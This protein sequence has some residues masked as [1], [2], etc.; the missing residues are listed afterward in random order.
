MI[1]KEMIAEKVFAEGVAKDIRNFLPAKYENAEFQVMQMNKNNG[2]QMV[3]VQ[4]RL[5]EENVCPVVYVEPFFNEIRLGE[6]VEKVMNEIAKC[7]EEAGNAPFVHNGINPMDYDSVKEHLAVM[8]VNTQANKRMLQ[9]MPHENIEDLSAICYV[10][11]P[12]ESNDGKATMKV[13]NEHL[14][15]WNVDAKEMFHQARANTQPV[16][17]PILQSMDEMMLSIFNEEGH[18]TNLLDE[19]VD[20]GFRSHDMLYALTN[21]EKQYGASMITQPEVLNKLEQLFPEGFYVLPSSVHEVLIVPDNG[22]MEPKMLGE[23]V[24]EVNKNEVERQ[25][26]LSDRVYSYDKE[27]HQIRQ[28]PDSIQKVKKSGLNREAYLRQLI[29]GV[30]PRDAPPPDYYS[31]MRELHKIG[32]NLNQ[33]AQKAHVLNVIDVQRYDQ[34]VWKFN[35]AVR[36][37]TEAVILPEKNESWQ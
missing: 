23:M 5:Q 12:V 16:N 25:E 34:E 20:F 4:V 26:V 32:N 29:S 33:I 17:T 6:P 31:M 8:L 19:N 9:E 7:M 11:F 37:I 27:K 14:K 30:V 22:E 13:K 35:E 15:M 28:E 24:R 10:D 36:K 18:A 1:V 3:G 21:V 2:V